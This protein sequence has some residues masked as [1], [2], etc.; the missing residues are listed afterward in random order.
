MNESHFFKF[1]QSISSD[2]ED[3]SEDILIAKQLGA[4]S[5]L[6]KKAFQPF[7]KQHE[8]TGLKKISPTG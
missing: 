4:G 8:I 2:S 3:C 1:N 5:V 7:E 6:D